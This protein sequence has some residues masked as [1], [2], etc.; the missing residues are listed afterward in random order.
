MDA[1]TCMHVI[2]HLHDLVNLMQET[3][4]L[5]KPG[6]RAYFE[7]PHPKSLILSSPPGRAAGS[8]TLNFFDDRTHVR[9]VAMGAFAQDLHDRGLNVIASGISR[10]WLFAASY[11][12]YI[13]LPRSR[14]KHIARIHW[15][16]WSAYL[17]GQRPASG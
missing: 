5:L 13:F 11:L 15:L 12:I 4:R 17:I 3:T 6:G 1:I 9:P 8:F 16:G 7:T 10:N 2:E 14:K